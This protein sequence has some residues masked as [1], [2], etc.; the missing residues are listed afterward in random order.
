MAIEGD[1]TTSALLTN[2]EQLT[3]DPLAGSNLI[4]G[5]AA[6]E[7]F[8]VAAFAEALADT[9][10]DTGPVAAS[11]ADPMQPGGLNP[12]PSSTSSSSADEK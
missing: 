12:V 5:A 1:S 9:S 11:Q 2:L 7:N 6:P 4:P 10:T 8:N 3:S